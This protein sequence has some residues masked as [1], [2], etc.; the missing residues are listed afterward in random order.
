MLLISIIATIL[1]VG[2][3]ILMRYYWHHWLRLTNTILPIDFTPETTIEI[4][5]PARNEASNIENCIASLLLLDYPKELFHITLIDDFSTDNTLEIML[6]YA[7]DN[8][9][10]IE[11]KNIVPY[12]AQ[13]NKKTA[14]ATAIN[15]T[16]A[17]LIVTTDADCNFS[18]KWL[19]YFAYKY[20]VD[21]CKIIAAPVLFTTNGSVFEDF[22][23]LD[24]CG[25]MGI[26]GAGIHSKHM[27]MCNGANLAYD[28]K[29][30]LE[31]GGFE[32]MATIA[33]GDDML[34]MQKIAQKH[35]NKIGFIK[36]KNATV[37]SNP[38][39]TYTSFLNQ[40]LRWASKSG[41]YKQWWI[42]AE[43]ILVWLFCTLIIVL[44]ILAPFSF[45]YSIIFFVLLS[46]KIIADYPLLKAT[47]SYF[48][49][50]SLLKVFFIA[51]FYHIIYI[52]M[53]GWMKL[54]GQKA[55]WKGR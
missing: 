40:R 41:H 10:I 16:Q 5:V 1:A 13:S 20:E 6:R 38:M 3:W 17:Q 31:V 30:Y 9:S 52:V 45:Q 34:L 39:E 18:P 33:S 19:Q 22:Q 50:K 26:T 36:S 23:A 37:F 47:S 15:T 55:V 21:N 42:D 12:V 25:M 4:I 8:I 54:F 48:G 2:Y 43:L 32:D 53:I 24:Y 51:Q 11:M 27:Y 7:S 29:T 49:Q 46:T 28:R 44:Q 14:I 35:S